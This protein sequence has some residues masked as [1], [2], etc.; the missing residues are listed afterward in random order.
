[1][2]L[3]GQEKPA[4]TPV[5]TK[6]DDTV[7]GL[8]LGLKEQVGRIEGKLDSRPCLTHAERM[9]G[10][11]ARVDTVEA[12]VAKQGWGRAL[13]IAALVGLLSILGVITGNALSS[14]FNLKVTASYWPV[15]SAAAAESLP[16]TPPLVDTIESM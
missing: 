15:T 3:V 14:Y 7:V 8:L 5:E 13:L 4:A 6:M 11:E 2:R 9:T 16:Y 12:V 10:I 1:M